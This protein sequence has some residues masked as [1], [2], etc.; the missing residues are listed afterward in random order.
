[1]RSKWRRTASPKEAE[2]ERARAL[3]RNLALTH[4]L[5]GYAKALLGRGEE[6]EGHVLESLPLSPHDC[7]F[8][9]FFVG[10]AKHWLGNDEEAVAWL[11]RSRLDEARAAPQAGLALDPTF[12]IRRYRAGAFGDNLTYLAQRERTIDGMR[13]A[14]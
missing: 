3:D 13:K 12:T 1:V 8:F 5:V 6:T 7:H 2:C 10:L 9:S 14:A 11:R 4:G